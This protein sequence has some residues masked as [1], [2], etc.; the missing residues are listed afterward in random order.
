VSNGFIKVDILDQ[1]KGPLRKV[2]ER[3]NEA[4]TTLLEFLEGSLCRMDDK[5]SWKNV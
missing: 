4:H 5:I 3:K 2:V 1:I